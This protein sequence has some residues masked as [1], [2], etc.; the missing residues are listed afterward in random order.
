[1]LIS[2]KL[3][4]I[5]RARTELTQEELSVISEKEGWDIVYKNQP[6]K[7]NKIEICFTGFS[8]LRRTELEIVAIKNNLKVVKSVT[9]SLDY[10]CVG[11]NAGPSK[12]EKAKKQKVTLITDLE[13]IDSMENR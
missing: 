4:Q 6:K 2:K 8:P 11:G 9:V 13:F 3:L 12:V 1:M 10:L 5:L 7:E